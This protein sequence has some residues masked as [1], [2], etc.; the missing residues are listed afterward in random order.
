MHMFQYMMNNDEIKA[1]IGDCII[2]GSIH[3]ERIIIV[4]CCKGGF[5]IIVSLNICSRIM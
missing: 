1:A 2:A 3:I 5:T 4:D